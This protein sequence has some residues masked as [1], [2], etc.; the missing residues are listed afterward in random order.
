[1]LCALGA[2]LAAGVGLYVLA[3]F[4]TVFMAVVLWLVEYFE[5]VA[6]KVFELTVKLKGAT[7]FRPKLEGVLQG[8]GVEYELLAESDEMVSY[9]TAAPIGVRTLDVSDMLRFLA[10]GTEM[11]IEWD[12]KRGKR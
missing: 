1:M 12:E 7:D 2:G 11:S 9:G 3:T 10:H 4:A 5:P 6:R 8:L